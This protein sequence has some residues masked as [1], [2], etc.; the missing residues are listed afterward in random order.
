MYILVSQIHDNVNVII[1]IKNMYEIKGVITTG[2]LC[3]HFLNRSI[4]FLPKRDV[5][6]K[7][8]EQRLIKINV[9]FI[10]EISG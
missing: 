2:D 10:S 5:F 7:P 1:E 4:P 3:L 9:A 6:L 8:R